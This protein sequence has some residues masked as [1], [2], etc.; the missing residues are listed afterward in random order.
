MKPTQIL[1]LTATLALLT[2]APAWA[3]PATHGTTHTPPGVSNANP[4]AQTPSTPGPN[5]SAP[6]KAK[7]YGRF[8]QSESKKHISGQQGTPFSQCVTALAKLASGAAKGPTSACSTLSKKH[9]AGQKGTPFSQC[10]T[11]AAK[12][13]ASKHS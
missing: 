2:T 5:A 8:C 7:A 10:V 13:L 6:A 12:L 1:A 4:H 3:V 11:A 9:I